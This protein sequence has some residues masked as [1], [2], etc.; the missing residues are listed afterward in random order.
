MI[1]LDQQTYLKAKAVGDH[2]MSEKAGSAEIA[3]TLAG[4][5]PGNM[6]KPILVEL[7]SPHRKLRG[8]GDSDLTPMFPDEGGMLIS[9]RPKGARLLIWACLDH[10]LG[11]R[12]SHGIHKVT[13]EAAKLPY[14]INYVRNS[15]LPTGRETYGNG[16]S[17]VVRE[18]ESHL[19][20]EGR[21]VSQD[22]FKWRHA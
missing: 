8:I 17:I 5:G 6:P 11:I 20:G 12:M 10:S 15:G 1:P 3:E 7:Q 22:T 4:R 16:A 9:T 19:H 21:Q 2:S 13:N 18:W 14:Y